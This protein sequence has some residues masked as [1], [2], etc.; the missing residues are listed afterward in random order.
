MSIGERIRYLRKNKLLIKSADDFGEKIGISGS[1]VRNIENS[2]I[3]ATDRV[4]SDICTVFSVNEHWLRNGGTDDSIFKQLSETE[5]LTMYTQLILDS[6]DDIV[7]DTIKN[8][9]VIYQKLDGDSKTVLKNVA[10]DLLEKMNTERA[11]T[12]SGLTKEQIDALNPTTE[13]L[14][15]LVIDEEI[16]TKKRVG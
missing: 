15:T 3:N 1:N 11:S 4:I 7:L 2:R 5:E 12:H 8:F 9:M 13:E 14:Q 10:K 6:T 16:K